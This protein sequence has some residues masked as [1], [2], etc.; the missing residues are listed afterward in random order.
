MWGARWHEFSNP[1]SHLWHRRVAQ[2]M[3]LWERTN[4]QL[5]TSVVHNIDDDHSLNSLLIQPSLCFL[6]LPWSY[7]LS[8]DTSILF[9]F[10]SKFLPLTLC[11]FDSPFFNDPFLYFL[12]VL[13]NHSLLCSLPL[14]SMSYNYP[15]MPL[16]PLKATFFLACVLSFHHQY[17]FLSNSQLP[18][19]FI[20]H[21]WYYFPQLYWGIIFNSTLAPWY[22]KPTHF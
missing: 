22:L 3:L 17:L 5:I 19:I 11:S 14:S 20:Y 2:S 7:R 15:E 6:L 18:N 12:Q 9:D 10:H 8:S 13:F 16:L 4:S 1:R 21:T